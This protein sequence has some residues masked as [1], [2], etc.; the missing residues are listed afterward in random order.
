[1]D[2]FNIFISLGRLVIGRELDW[3]GVAAVRGVVDVV[4]NLRMFFLKVWTFASESMSLESM[5]LVVVVVVVVVLVLLLL[6]LL[7]CWL[8][9]LLESIL[10]RSPELPRAQELSRQD[11]FL[12]FW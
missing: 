8:V 7:L 12:G 11:L 5:L 9:S 4:E 1:M 3:N 10:G 6:L 2:A